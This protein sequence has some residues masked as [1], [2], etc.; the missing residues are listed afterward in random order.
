MRERENPNWQRS[1]LPI[2]QGCPPPVPEGNHPTRFSTPAPV[3][4]R[5]NWVQWAKRDCRMRVCQYIIMDIVHMHSAP[6]K[7]YLKEIGHDGQ[8]RPRIHDRCQ[9]NEAAEEHDLGQSG[10]PELVRA[11]NL[12]VPGAVRKDRL[13]VIAVGRCNEASTAHRNGRAAGRRPESAHRSSPRDWHGYGADREGE[14]PRCPPRAGRDTRTDS[15]P[16]YFDIAH[17][18]VK[19]L[20]CPTS[21]EGWTN[22]VPVWCRVS[23]CPLSSAS[24][25]SPLP[26]SGSTPWRSDARGRP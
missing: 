8:A 22:S 17:Q 21:S 5:R 14:R 24:N 16:L 6:A 19:S 20:V 23:P 10:D 2:H 1:A 3:P 9:A 25:D 15:Y 26:R 7:M 12:T 18:W 11:I 13:V 4:D